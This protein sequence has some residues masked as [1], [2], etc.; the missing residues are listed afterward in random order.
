MHGNSSCRLEAVDTLKPVL[1]QGLSLLAFDFAGCGHSDGDVITLGYLEKEDLAA[2]VTYLRANDVSSIALWGRSMGAATALLYGSRDPG[3]KAMV[4][5]SPF[6]SLQQLVREVVD[7]APVR[8]KPNVAVNAVLRL[9]RA[10]IL[11]KTGMDI[12]R[13]RPAENV[14]DCAMPAVFLVGS[15]DTFIP[16]HHTE[17]IF[18]QYAGEK[19]LITVDGGHNSMRPTFAMEAAVAV[20]KRAMNPEPPPPPQD[21]KTQ[22]QQQHQQQQQECQGEPPPPPQDLKTQHQQ[23]QQEQQQQECQGSPQLPEQH[24]SLQNSPGSIEAER[25]LPQNCHNPASPGCR[26]APQQQGFAALPDA[27]GGLLVSTAV[28]T[29]SVA[30]EQAA[31]EPAV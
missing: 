18:K 6:A 22:H 12:M 17:A 30:I 26:R 10:T 27:G 1:G 21:L 14:S 8:F 31:V 2:V 16:P 5:D 15:E 29:P 19:R 11:R 13:L 20:L 25:L 9:V 23:Q 24:M 28:A 4:L 3:I 7:R